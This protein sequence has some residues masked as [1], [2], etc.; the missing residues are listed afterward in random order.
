M[1][2]HKTISMVEIIEKTKQKV[3]TSHIQS[4]GAE[5]ILVSVIKLHWSNYVWTFASINHW[6]T[7]NYGCVCFWSR[8]AM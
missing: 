6:P 4:W 2:E 7:F 3:F 8:G 5:C 1:A